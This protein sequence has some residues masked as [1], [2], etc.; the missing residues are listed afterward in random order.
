MGIWD[1]TQDVNAGGWQ[2]DPW[3]PRSV[4]MGDGGVCAELATADSD[5]QMEK[6]T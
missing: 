6:V 1:T 2:G 3:G 4:W 5:G